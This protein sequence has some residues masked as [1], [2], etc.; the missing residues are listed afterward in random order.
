[1]S[2][3]SLR[4]RQVHLDFHTSGLI[5]DVG[6]RF[7]KVQFQE[8]LKLGHVDSVTVFAKCHHGWSYHP[9]QVGR[10]HPQLAFDLL[11]SQIEACREIGVRCP[12]YLSAGLDELMAMEHPEWIVKR[13]D[14]RTYEPLALNIFKQLRFN[15]PYLDYLCAQIEEVVRLWPDN[16]GIFLDI[17][18]P[19]LD[20]SETSLREMLALG[21]DPARET[22]VGNHA[23]RVLLRY[24]EQTTAA[25]RA[26]RTDTAVFHNGGHV[27]VGAHTINGFNSHY[28]LESLPTGGWGYDHFALSARYAITQPRNFLG[29]TGKFHTT[30]GE[31]GGFKRSAALRYE[32]GAILAYG[33][34][35]SVG[36]Q[37][38]PDGRMNPDT[39]R[40]I[41]AA[42][43]EVET[44][45]P[46]CGG[47]CSVAD[48]G[49]VSAESDQD[50][51]RRHD[52]VSPAD[53]GVARM[54]LELHVPFD[55]LDATAA[56]DRYNVVV[57]PDSLTLT[58]GLEA[59]LR[60]HLARGGRV[61]AAG[62]ALLSTDGMR[63]AVDVGARLVGRSAANPDY[64][65]ATDLTPD[66]PVRSPIVIHGGAYELEPA[67]ARVLAG[68]RIP[69]FNRTWERFC[70]HQHAPDAPQ[71]VSPAAILHGQIA[72]FAHDI[73]LRY[74]EYGQPLYRDFVAA[75]IKHLMG[76]NLPVVT[77]LPR[78][79]RFNLLEQTAE[80]RYVA[81][82]LYAPKSLRG[83]T[84]GHGASRS[85]EI[86][87]DLVSLRD[88]EINLRV[89]RRIIRVQLVPQRQTIEFSQQG[90]EV[91][92]TVPEFVAHQM[93]ELAYSS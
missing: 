82:L 17:V 19:R 92:F 73:F 49:V 36:D 45:E 84:A 30:W 46:W 28:E 57:L 39:Y 81:H 11:G 58:A 4:F 34:K 83:S 79:G 51:A 13:R 89:P 8:A 56:W 61:L 66:V 1:M 52:T 32:C 7:Q 75:A 71:E 42:Y 74:R 2:T 33:G 3:H 72:Y 68:R 69:F 93:I 31:F 60:A 38:H 22:D 40:L 67:G 70:S 77:T 16:D 50:R 85:V 47:V 9:T 48:V 54:L 25:A 35:C 10:Q 27:P 90:G 80:H 24:Y 15:S 37:L 41:G 6:A 5:P 18:G 23:Q 86:I 76:G 63:F 12:I 64:L 43:A 88:V 29:M 65:V 20:Y 44:K 14:G 26:V 21:L 62:S 87:E 53:E 55:V 91:S 78:D 59:R